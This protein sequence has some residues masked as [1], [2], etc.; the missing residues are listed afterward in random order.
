MTK[1]DFIAMAD[2]IRE[3]NHETPEG[4]RFTYGQLHTIADV[5]EKRNPRFMRQ[6]WFGYIS[7]QN[8]PNGGA[9]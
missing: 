6:R 1:Q 8:G 4:G 9:K 3:H 7:G 2:A 5:F